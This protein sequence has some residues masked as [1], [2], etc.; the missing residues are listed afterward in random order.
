MIVA[1]GVHV[2]PTPSREDAASDAA[3]VHAKDTHV[4]AGA[5]TAKADALITLDR[6]HLFAA[7]IRQAK[8]PFEILTPAMFLRRLLAG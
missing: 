1:P 3:I 5:D 6:K 4:L 2:V 7:S 8:L